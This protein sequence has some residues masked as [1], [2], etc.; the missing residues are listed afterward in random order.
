MISIGSI[1]T[2]DIKKAS[3]ELVKRF[4]EKFRGDFEENKKALNELKIIDHT[5]MRNK[6]AGYITRIAK[7]MK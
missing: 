3:F 5:R 6:V 4:P 1:R 2:A 7:R